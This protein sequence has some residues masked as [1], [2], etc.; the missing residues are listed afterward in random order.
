MF[1]FFAP[2][3]LW[4]EIAALVAV[5][6]GLAWGVH[7]YNTHQQGIGEARVRAEYVERDRLSAENQRLREQ[8]LQKDVDNAQAQAAKDRQLASAA[9]VAAANTGR[10][11]SGTLT[12]V[13]A[14]VATA[15]RDALA[16]NVT[17]L[18]TVLD[19]CQQRYLWMAGQADG[20]AADSIMYQR[21]WP[22]NFPQPTQGKP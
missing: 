15:T 7:A 19:N 5:L 20:H 10:L 13:T 16:T 14:N 2:Y 1:A 12:T 18:A 9:A 17:T 21:G 22:K 3:K 6:A 11:F 4:F 8:S